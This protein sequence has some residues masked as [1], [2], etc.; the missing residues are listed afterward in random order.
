[1]ALVASDVWEIPAGDLTPEQVNLQV[2]QL[3][4]MHQELSEAIVMMGRH[5]TAG[6]RDYELPGAECADERGHRGWC[7]RARTPR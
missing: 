2:G 7:P 3:T 1:M 6:G 4:A 5:A